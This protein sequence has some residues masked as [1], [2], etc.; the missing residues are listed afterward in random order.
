M[1]TQMDTCSMPTSGRWEYV[2]PW[3]N[4]GVLAGTSREDR[5]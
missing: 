3:R 4:A 1:D 5:K 2:Q